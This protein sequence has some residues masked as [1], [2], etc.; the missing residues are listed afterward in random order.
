MAARP[1]GEQLSFDIDEQQA[2]QRLPRVAPAVALVAD[3]P[4]DDPDWFFEPWWPGAPVQVYIDDD[5]LRV[6]GGHMAD[7]LGAFPELGSVADQFA[8]GGLIVE[9]ALLVLD[10][11]GRPDGHLLRSRLETDQAH[12]GQP[13]IVASDLLYER[14]VSLLS[15]P[16][17]ERRERL[18]RQ[19]TD[20]PQC[21]ASRGL[22][23]E[24]LT[25]ADALASMGMREISARQLAARYRPGQQDGSWLRMPVHET[26]QQVPTRPLLAVLQRLPL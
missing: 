26:E 19:L 17:A 5:G 16:F 24:G 20:G 12:G 11:E 13:A 6:H 10:E 21:V 4:F 9:G 2:G 18:T 14:G 8:D 25:L 22:R 3:G 15:L 1:S 7:P 23:G